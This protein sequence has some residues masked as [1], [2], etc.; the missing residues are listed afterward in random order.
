MLEESAIQHNKLFVVLWSKSKTKHCSFARK[1]SIYITKQHRP[2]YFSIR[3]YK[4]RSDLP[5]TPLPYCSHNAADY[6][7]SRWSCRPDFYPTYLSAST[8]ESG[9]QY[10]DSNS[11]LILFYILCLTLTVFSLLRRNDRMWKFSKKGVPS[12]SSRDP[13]WLSSASNFIIY[14]Y[15]GVLN[16]SRLVSY[17]Y[18]YKI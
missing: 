15:A 18:K 13:T 8:S 2:P 1:G 5:L 16:S 12:R 9:A 10:K 3:S 4:F 14:S 17:T 11:N 7:P 6:L